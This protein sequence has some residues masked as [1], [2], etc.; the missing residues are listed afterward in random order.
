MEAMM[1]GEMVRMSS[2]KV[3]EAASEMGW[4]GT[5]PSLGDPALW[6]SISVGWREMALHAKLQMK[7]RQGPP[8]GGAGQGALRPLTWQ[9]PAPVAQMRTDT[10]RSVDRETG[11]FL[12]AGD[13]RY[14]TTL[15]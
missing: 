11:N 8:V 15:A 4:A 3:Q 7:G 5:F 12:S 1:L 13:P 10:Y 2:A 9:E 14:Q 6:A